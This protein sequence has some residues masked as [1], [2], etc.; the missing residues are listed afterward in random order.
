MK[1]LSLRE[2]RRLAE[3]PEV[4]RTPSRA[5]GI[6]I[7]DDEMCMRDV[8]NIG[9]RNYGF[10]VWLAADGQEALDVYR[11]HHEAIDVVLMDVRMPGLDGPQTLAGLQAQN[12]QGRRLF[13]G[14][15]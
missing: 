5:C 4:P 2:Q 6:L 8:L 11:R 10:A 7:V 9:M 14:G 12:P 13:M 3:L 15:R 1:K